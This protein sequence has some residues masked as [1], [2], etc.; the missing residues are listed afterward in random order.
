MTVTTTKAT[1]VATAGPTAPPP[2][3]GCCSRLSGDCVC[4][5][6]ALLGVGV[7]VTGTNDVLADAEAEAVLLGMREAEAVLLGMREADALTEAET[8]GEGDALESWLM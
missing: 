5:D 3:T 8:L 7:T 6:V 1:I 4:D 2:A